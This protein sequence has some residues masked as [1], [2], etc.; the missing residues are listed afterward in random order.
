ME[1]ITQSYPVRKF[2]VNY[3][4]QEIQHR[5]LKLYAALVSDALEHMGYHSQCMASG[6]YPLTHTM[7]VAG[8]AFTAHGIATP[9]RDTKIHDIRLG[10]FKSMTH[11]VVQI[12]DTQG[13][14]SCG[15]FGEISATAA[16]AHG[17]VGA[18]ID[19]STRDSN[20]LI[21]MNFP[22]FCRFR[23]PVEAFGRFMVVDY[24]IPIYVKGM[25]GLLQVNP[26][27][28]IFGDND[29]V[30]VVPFELTIPVLELAEEWFASEAK[31]RQAMA[32]GRNPFDVY[33][34]FGRF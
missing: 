28:Y 29:G 3:D 12:R 30:V 8:P 6:I 24:Q 1:I 13:D 2:E 17:C 26:G 15:Q 25:Q 21:D 9:S 20:Y 18:V 16:H 32:T 22:T 7:K 10:M 14:T 23:N 19:G 33:E 5:Y 27:D 31:S 4:W 11:G 34:E